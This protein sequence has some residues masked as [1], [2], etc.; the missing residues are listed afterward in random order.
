MIFMRPPQAGHSETSMEN[1]R[2]RSCELLYETSGYGAAELDTDKCLK[3]IAAGQMNHGTAT[4]YV[5]LKRIYEVQTEYIPILERAVELA[6]SQL[7]PHTGMFHGPEGNP[8]GDTWKEYG[9][10]AQ[11]MK[12]MLRLI[13]YMGVENMPYRH[14]RADTLLKNQDWFR[15]SSISVKRNTTEM[16]IQCLLESPYQREE[17]LKAL[18]RHSK[19]VMED[20]PWKLH[21]TGDYTAYALMMFGPYLNWEGYEGRAPRTPFPVGAEYDYRVEV[22]PFGRCAN[23]IKKRPQELLWH[24]D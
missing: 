5:V 12:G 11:T 22:G 18:D 16:M 3:Q 24:K 13:G 21:M 20:E 19:V 14:V 7:S 1:T 23:V 17:L 10:T 15:K 8:S 9:A 6:I 2:A 4:A